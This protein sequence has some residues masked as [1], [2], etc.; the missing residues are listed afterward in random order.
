MCGWGARWAAASSSTARERRSCNLSMPT[1]PTSPPSSSGSTG[2][3]FPPWSGRIR[4]KAV[5]QVSKIRCCLRESR[6]RT[7]H[8]A[9]NMRLV[10]TS[11]GRFWTS[12]QCQVLAMLACLCI[13]SLGAILEKCRDWRLWLCRGVCL[14]DLIPFY[15][16]QWAAKRGESITHKVSAP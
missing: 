3:S 1:G 4:T 2:A 13:L 8:I 12:C 16:G 5:L 14:S 15:A 11:I 6:L 10:G 7:P 9:A